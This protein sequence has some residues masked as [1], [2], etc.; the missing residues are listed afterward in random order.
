M[1]GIA[2]VHLVRKQNG[3]LSFDQFL[4]SYREHPA[5]VA[6]ELV[7]LFKGFRGAGDTL[8][9]DRLIG[10]LPHRREFIPDTGF[11]L[12]AYFGAAQRLD[13]GYFCFLN[14]YSRILDAGWLAKLYRWV[15][16]KDVGLTGASGSWQSVAGG[17][18]TQQRPG[19]LHGKA[20]SQ[21][22]QVVAALRDRRPGMLQR[23]AWS[24]LLRLAGALKPGRNFPPFPNHHIRTNAFMGARPTLLR[25]RLGPMRTKFSAYK[26]E[27]GIDSMT[28]QVLRLGLRVLVV[29]RDGEGYPPERWHASNTFWQS[30]QENLLVADNQTDAYLASDPLWAAKL[31]YSAWGE[32]ARCS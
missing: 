27:S 26:F 3:I 32:L 17:Y 6:H 12:H 29:G 1:S 14:S 20:P 4:R 19:H 21:I 9:H 18:A 11:D 10:D 31:S 25:L 22:S 30:S 28:N 24:L 16:Q 15:V 8:E 5:G 13:Y 23:R 7:I 2:V